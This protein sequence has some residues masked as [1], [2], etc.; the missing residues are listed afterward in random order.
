LRSSS[1]P[2]SLSLVLHGL[3]GAAD[4]EHLDHRRLAPGHDEAEQHGGRVLTGPRR[5][6]AAPAT[7][8]SV[9]EPGGG[10]GIQPPPLVNPAQEGRAGQG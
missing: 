1:P 9:L 10:R 2:S 4:H 3:L 8:A 6:G 5:L 7:C